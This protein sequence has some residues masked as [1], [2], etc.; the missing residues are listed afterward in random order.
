MKK[1]IKILIYIIMSTIALACLIEIIPNYTTVDK[2]T[3]NGIYTLKNIVLGKLEQTVLIRGYDRTNP[4]IVFLHGGPGFANIS[5]VKKYQKDIEKNFVVVNWDQ[6]GAGKSF[7]LFIDKN[8]MTEEHILE[9]LDQLIL[10]LCKEFNKQKVYIA[11]HSWG[12][13]LGKDYV[14]LH[15]EKVEYYISIGQYVS[16][17]ESDLYSYRYLLSEA[18][19][20]DDQ[21]TLTEL[22]KIDEPP[23]D[24][25][26]EKQWKFRNIINKYEGDELTINVNNEMLL[27][28]ITEPEYSLTDLLKL[29]IGNYYSLYH[30][31]PQFSDRDFRNENLGFEVPVLFI[32]GKKDLVTNNKLAEEYFEIINCSNKELIWFDNSA[33]DPQ[34]EEVEKFSNILDNIRNKDDSH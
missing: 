3:P 26:I 12:T 34:Y 9:D 23:Y 16:S 29:F 25:N 8:T 4:V 24:G 18:K 14:Q 10:Y 27:G 2:D 19:K 1:K 31:Y 32:L 5:F 7:S 13:V 20:K 28:T 17:R 33:H 30:L 15:P 6:R 22:R 11:G 21:S